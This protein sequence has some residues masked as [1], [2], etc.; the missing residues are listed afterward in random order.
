[1]NLM[2]LAESGCLPD[3]AI[4]VGI[5]RLLA[6]RCKQVSSGVD[7]QRR[8]LNDFVQRMRQSPLA[9]CTDQANQQHY[10]VPA[11]FFRLVLGPRLKY[12]CCLYPNAKCSLEVGEEEMLELTCQRAEIA[13][14][15]DV[16][17]LG[18]GWGS[19]TLW[20]AERF[21]ACKV[22]GISNSNS[23]REFIESRSRSLGLTNVEVLTTDICEFDTDC[24]FDRVVSLEMF[25]H[26]RNYELLFSRIS[27]WLY[28]DGKLFV[29]IFCHRNSPYLFETQGAANWIGR[30]FFTGGMMPSDDLFL[31][32]QNDLA[33]QEH[34]CLNGL[35]Y[36]RTCEAWLKNLDRN[37][38]AATSL[39]EKLHGRVKAPVFVQRWRMF[40]MACAELFRYRDGNEWFVS[41]YLFANHARRGSTAHPMDRATAVNYE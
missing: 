23:Q 27:D 40:F 25:E 2:H 32:F 22:T 8:H 14:G 17:E 7:A 18:C 36:A 19:L 3:W 6:Q 26:L 11:E 21:P 1:M 28:D 13:N 15:M 12:S 35:H 20:I 38:A 39:F 4:R 5:R 37:R 9:V 29:H 24:K 10:E 30:H 16:L 33:I 31:H 41:H 34:W